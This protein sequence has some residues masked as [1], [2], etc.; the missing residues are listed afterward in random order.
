MEAGN[1]AA[2]LHTPVLPVAEGVAVGVT[3]QT[4]DTPPPSRGLQRRGS[5]VNADVPE[6]TED[7]EHELMIGEIKVKQR[8]FRVMFCGVMYA[9][10]RPIERSP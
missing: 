7:I 1:L 8:R 4:P 10:W 9:A 6:E 5:L 2:S 3:G